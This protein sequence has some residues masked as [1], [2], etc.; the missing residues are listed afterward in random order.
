MKNFIE[1]IALRNFRNIEEE[2][3]EFCPDVNIIYGDNGMGK[4]NIL[5]SIFVCSAGRSHRTHK[6]SSLI[7]YE[8]SYANIVVYKNNGRYRDKINVSIKEGEKKGIA[9]NGVSLKKTGDLFGILKTVMFSPEDM[10]LINEG[11]VARRR[12][13]DM[14]LC[15]LSPVY[16]DSLEKY[17]RVLKQRNNLLKTAGDPEYIKKTVF[18][19]DRQLSEYGAKI[20]KQRENFVEKISAFASKIY[21]GITGGREKFSVIYKPESYADCLEERLRRSIERDIY[22]KTTGNGPHKDDIVFKINDRDVRMFGSQGQKKSSVLSLKL[23]EIEVIKEETGELPVLLLDDV[24]SELD[25]A[26]QEYILR[27][28]KNM[29]IILTCTGFSNPFYKIP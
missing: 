28:L 27:N 18:M 12:F 25:S 20:I 6:I 21:E 14:E 3:V 10:S 7:N 16:C 23:S 13:M 15:Q 29:Q 17:F 8:K 19:W 26:R 22:Y 9:V 5:E 4:T 1:S 2:Y 24:L 11:P